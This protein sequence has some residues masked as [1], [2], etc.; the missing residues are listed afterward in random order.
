MGRV[1]V[2]LRRTFIWLVSRQATANAAGASFVAATDLDGS[3]G[4]T[5][6]RRQRRTWGLTASLTAVASKSIDQAED[7]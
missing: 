5:I 3:K 2:W 7:V 6:W 4:W 1:A